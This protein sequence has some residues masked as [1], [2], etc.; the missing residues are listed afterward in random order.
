MLP[1]AATQ[2]NPK[3]LISDKDKYCIISLTCTIFKNKS[4]EKSDLWSSEIGGE[5]LDEHDQKVQTSSYKT[6][7]YWGYNVQCDDY[8]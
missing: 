2:T 8:S 1:F 5:E 4:K 7:K 6:N 3:D